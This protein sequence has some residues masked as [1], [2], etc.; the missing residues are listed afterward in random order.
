M[1]RLKVVLLNK[2]RIEKETADI[3]IS[4]INECKMMLNRKHLG[5]RISASIELPMINND[6]EYKIGIRPFLAQ[7]WVS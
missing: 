1:N 4:S 7:P 6:G 5:M 3:I 2:K